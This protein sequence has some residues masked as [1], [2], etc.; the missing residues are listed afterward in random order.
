MIRFYIFVFYI[1]DR[2]L[3]LKIKR[4]PSSTKRCSFP[5]CA[6]SQNLKKMQETDRCYIAKVCKIYIPA[7]S[8]VCSV[9]ANKFSWRNDDVLNESNDFTD[10]YIEDM[11]QLLTNRTITID[12]EVPFVLSK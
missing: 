6:A 3:H 4:A 2:I 5:I 1:A 9:H 8:K 10:E 7:I 11:F 12:H